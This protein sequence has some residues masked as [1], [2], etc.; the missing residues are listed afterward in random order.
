MSPIM[1]E[2]ELLNRLAELPR[3]ISPGHDPWPQISARIE[4]AGAG[5]SRSV[6]GWMLSAV[7]ASFVLVFAAGLL[8]K[9]VWDPGSEPG[10]SQP[11]SELA[12]TTGTE[13]MRAAPGLLDTIDAEYVAAFREFNNIGESRDSLAPQT[14]EKIEMG[15]AELQVTETALAAALE[16]NPGDLFLNGRMLELRTRQLSFL[17]QLITIDRNNRRMKI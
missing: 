13:P 2:K 7:A 8:L 12:A 6:P 16:N 1:S 4:P 10:Q 9:P 3:E 5:S 11:A 15:W 17:K 14:L